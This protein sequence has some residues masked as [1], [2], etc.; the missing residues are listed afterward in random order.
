MGSIRRKLVLFLAFMTLLPLAACLDP[1]P[2]PLDTAPIW[3]TVCYD[4]QISATGAIERSEQCR[5]IVR[6]LSEDG[7]GP[8]RSIVLVGHRTA[9]V[10]LGPDSNI[11]PYAGREACFKRPREIGVDSISWRGRS[12]ADTV[13]AMKKGKFLAREVISEFPYCE[14]SIEKIPLNNFSPAYYEFL[15]H[16]RKRGLKFPS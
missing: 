11:P 1:K 4:E 5:L 10:V 2:R 6:Y 9:T 13:R 8:A 16:I 7:I 12:F 15:R 3:E 14:I